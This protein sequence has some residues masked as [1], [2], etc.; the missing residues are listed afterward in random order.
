[1]LTPEGNLRVLEQSE[2][3]A[4]VRAARGGAPKAEVVVSRFDYREIGMAREQLEAISAIR[5]A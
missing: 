4:M 1:L 2:I 5:G 3:D